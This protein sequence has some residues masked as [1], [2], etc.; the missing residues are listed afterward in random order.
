MYRLPHDFYPKVLSRNIWTKDK[1]ATIHPH[2]MDTN[3]HG[4]IYSRVNYALK[5]ISLKRP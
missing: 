5:R 2:E 3:T 1:A 4:S